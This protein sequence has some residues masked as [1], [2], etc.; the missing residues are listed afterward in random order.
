LNNDLSAAA[1]S[2]RDFGAKFLAARA[3]LDLASW[4]SQHGRA[5]TS[6]TAT[7]AQSLFAQLD[8]NPWVARCAALVG[9]S[10]DAAHLVTTPVA[11][12]G[13]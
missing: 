3:L 12:A 9:N 5:E 11:P 13:T 4:Q 7:Q 1:A 8:A 2:L 10:S 6:T